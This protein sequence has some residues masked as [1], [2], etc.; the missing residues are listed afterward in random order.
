MRSSIA[1][2][3]AAIVL[4]W[5]IAPVVAQT[6]AVETERQKFQ[7]HS[8]TVTCVAYSPDGKTLATGSYDKSVRL[9][10]MTR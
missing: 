1:S 7:G 8:Q 3:A 2:L 5:P 4:L 9:W 6:R 10:D